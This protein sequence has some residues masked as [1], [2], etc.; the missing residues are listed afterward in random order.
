[1]A[2]CRQAT[3]SVRSRHCCHRYGMRSPEH[4]PAHGPFTSPALRPSSSPSPVDFSSCGNILRPVFQLRAGTSFLPSI[5][6]SS[7]SQAA[8]GKLDRGASIRRMKSCC[9]PAQVGCNFSQWNCHTFGQSFFS[10]MEQPSH[11]PPAKLCP[12]KRPSQWSQFGQEAISPPGQPPW[13]SR[14]ISVHSACDA[15]SAEE[16]I[17]ATRWL[18]PLL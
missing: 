15:L 4:S 18:L 8:V 10:E 2:K 6:S 7:T 5:S 13:D 14:R 17:A 12:V 16:P 1:M 11:I 3:Q 9:L